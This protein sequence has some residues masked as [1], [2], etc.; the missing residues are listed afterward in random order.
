MKKSNNIFLWFIVLL[1]LVLRLVLSNQSFWLDEGASLMFAK[2]TWPQ[3]LES[4]KTDFHPPLFYWLLHL[5]LPIAG[6]SE[7]LIRLPFILLSTA[8]IPALYFLSR[9]VFGTKSKTPL[10]S[11]LFL[12]LNPLHVYYS[13][14]LRMYSLSAL[15]VVLSWYFLVKKKYILTGIFNLLGFFTFYGVIFSIVS[16]VIFVFFDKSKGKFRNITSITFPLVLF[17]ALWWPVFSTQLENGQYL[18]NILPG[19]QSLSGSLTLKSLFLIPLKFVF[20]RISFQ[21]QNLYLLVGG[22]ITSLF[23]LIAFNSF[24]DRK[25]RVFWMALIGPLALATIASLKS[26]VLGYWRFLF[27][28]P[29]FVVV[30]SAGIEDMPKITFWS[31]AVWVCGVFLF[32]NLYFWHNPRFHREDWRG[33]SIFVDSQ[34]SALL[35]AFPYRFAPLNF[36]LDKSIVIPMQ[37]PDYRLKPDFS[38]GTGEELK[39]VQVVY[40]LD[41]LSDLTDPSRRGLKSLPGLNL[42]QTAVYNFNNLG[43]LYEFQP[44]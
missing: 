10:L 7:W 39:N 28:L 30:I 6:K 4:I 29:F 11:V 36:Y 3:L 8:T 18:K 2:L 17:F 43:Q 37:T 41:Y 35:L 16:Q 32:S 44:L 12:A 23:A 33:L 20:G 42:K 15:L 22:V 34:K 25:A 21:P 19:W 24:R 31:V 40:Y 5:W 26:P 14:E 9:H 27:I 1:A 38:T 13:Q